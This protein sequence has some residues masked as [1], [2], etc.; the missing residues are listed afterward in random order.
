MNKF[1]IGVNIVSVSVCITSALLSKKSMNIMNMDKKI[2]QGARNEAAKY[3]TPAQI[4]KI[5]AYTYGESIHFYDALATQGKVAKA[6]QEG[7]QMVRDSIA[8]AAKTAI[9]H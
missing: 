2:E 7:A 9:R 5:D 3:A 1:L 8:K 4:A 6:Y